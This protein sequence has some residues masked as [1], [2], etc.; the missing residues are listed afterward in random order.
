[1]KALVARVAKEKGLKQGERM[2]D[3]R[4]ATGGKSI[5]AYRTLLK[6]LARLNNFAPFDILIITSDG[7][8]SG[9]RKKKQQLLGFAEKINFLHRDCNSRPI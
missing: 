9:Y 5:Q 4:A 3:V 6:D 7:N 8:F 2:D 1:M